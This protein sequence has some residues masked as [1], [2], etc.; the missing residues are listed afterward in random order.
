MPIDMALLEA[1]L[2]RFQAAIGYD[3][4]AIEHQGDWSSAPAAA[5]SAAR[6]K[7]ASAIRGEAHI[8]P[9]YDY[10]TAELVARGFKKSSVFPQSGA[11][12]RARTKVHGGFFEK[13][14]DAGVSLEHTGPLLIV[15]GKAMLTAP[16]ISRTE[17]RKQ[18]RTQPTS[19][20][21]TRCSVL[22]L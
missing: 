7:R 11:G 15:S 14:V 6:Q 4:I 9:I 2:S 17:L 1:A 5:V 19:T 10:C 21:A 8:R 16:A 18:L 12:R 20:R 22:A 3:A 13:E